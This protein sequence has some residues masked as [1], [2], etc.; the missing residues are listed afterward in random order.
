MVFSVEATAL[1]LDD[2]KLDST[3]TQ[4]LVN[5]HI[6]GGLPDDSELHVRRAYVLSYNSDLLVPKWA[7][8]H[9]TKEYRDTPKR[10]SRWKSF[11]T[12]PELPIVLDDD[13]LGWYASEYNFARG[14]IAPYFISGGDRDGDG[15]DAEIE[16]NLKIEDADDACTV[17]EINAMS[18][19]APQYHSK[20][21][22]SPGVW[23]TLETAVRKMVEADNEFHVIAGSI[24]FN[25]LAVQ[26]IGDIEGEESNW[27]IGV[28]HGYFKL[29]IDSQNNEAVGFLFDHQADLEK[30]CDI[31]ST[32]STLPSDCI[33]KIEDI[34][35]VTGLRF[36]SELS[37]D[38]SKSLRDSSTNETW[39]KWIN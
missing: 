28:P 31:P 23:Y 10:K 3:E 6:F 30:G 18:N 1:G 39:D 9:V 34:E 35:S 2:C 5:E 14:H 29:V 20:F 27:E 4:S 17:F 7:A 15:K 32:G 8:W 11:R 19:I 21:N 24:F 25:G 38:T 37:S 36:F 16:S 12:D 26:K 22:G 33:V 13:Y